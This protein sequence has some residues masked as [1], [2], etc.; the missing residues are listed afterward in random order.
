MQQSCTTVKDFGVHGGEDLA[1]GVDLDEL[2]SDSSYKI[3]I[4]LQQSHHSED[5]E[6]DC[7]VLEKKLS[8][9]GSNNDVE[10][11][12]EVLLRHIYI[13]ICVILLQKRFKKVL[14][15][16]QFVFLVLT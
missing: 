10:I 7:L 14:S 4:S 3:F 1:E 2:I 12:L 11:A 8:A 13:Y 5:R 6:L 15:L 9:T 16:F